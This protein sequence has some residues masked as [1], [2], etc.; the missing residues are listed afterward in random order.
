MSNQ[1]EN[2]VFASV[3]VEDTGAI[4]ARTAGIASVV[5]E[6]VGSYLVTL[7]NGIGDSEETHSL[8]VGVI[9]KGDPVGIWP[10]WGAVER[11]DD[12]HYRIRTWIHNGINPPTPDPTDIPWAFQLYRVSP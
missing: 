12:T 11:V 4:L 10:A 7:V 8:C 9:D 2:R 3:R 6:A 5:N 1:R